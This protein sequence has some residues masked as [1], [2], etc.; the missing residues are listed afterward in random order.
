MS[1]TSRVL[2][3]FSTTE[4]SDSNT[5]NA[6]DLAGSTLN[7]PTFG[8]DGQI[9]SSGAVRHAQDDLIEEEP[10]PPYLHVRLNP[11][12]RHR[13]MESQGANMT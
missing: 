3:L 12:G 9:M 4:N 5:S 8:F 13:A 11:D 6:H 1:V 10:R 2:G 7:Q